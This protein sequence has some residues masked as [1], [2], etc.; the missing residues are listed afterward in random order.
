VVDPM[1]TEASEPEPMRIVAYDVES[2]T[3]AE[4]RQ[5]PDVL[6]GQRE[7]ELNDQTVTELLEPAVALSPDG[8]RLA[9]VHADEDRVTLLDARNLTIER[10]VSLERSS[11]LWDL[12][13]PAVAYAKEI[14]GIIR[15]AEFSLDGQYLY[16]YNVIQEAPLVP[17]EA[18]P[19]QR[20]LWLVD[21]E[22]SLI[23]A[24][25]LAGYQIQWVR[26]APDGTV[27]VFGTTDER[28]GPF[29]I[30]PS[31]PSMLWRLDALTL[32][33]LAERKFTGY[34]GGRVIL[35]HSTR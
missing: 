28:L 1:I 8:R 35:D 22:R 16:L 14:T 5:L 3:K 24:E 17:G 2:E 20:S 23:A 29:E 6:I 13:A 15:Q 27:Y 19:E 34:R 31:S 12:F 10:T 7:T 4:E 9:I 25:A 11:S 21:L 30:R 26:P 32:E 18:R 33:I